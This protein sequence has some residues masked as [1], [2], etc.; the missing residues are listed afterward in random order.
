MRTFFVMLCCIFFAATVHATC[1]DKMPASTPNSQLI[2][3]GDGTVTD[4]K[5]ELMWKKCLEGF[6][7]DSCGKGSLDSFTWQ[8]ALEQPGIVN[9][10]S[11]FAGYTDWRLPNIK[12]LISIVEEQCSNPAMN[13]D[14][15]PYTSSSTLHVWSGSPHYVYSGY[16]WYV[17]FSNGNSSSNYGQRYNLYA[18]RLVRSGQ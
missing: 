8:E 11:G 14:R 12:E 10:G 1:N 2:D 5:T 3:N 6:S 13:V 16:A 9:T 17:D 7:G 18:V 4:L 15:F